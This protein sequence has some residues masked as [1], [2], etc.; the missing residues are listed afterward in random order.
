MDFQLCEFPMQVP[1]RMRAGSIKP[2]RVGWRVS[3]SEGNSAAVSSMQTNFQILSYA[4]LLTH[5]QIRA[6]NPPKI[7]V[8]F[9]LYFPIAVSFGCARDFASPC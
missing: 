3:L 1:N 9:Q 5:R 8:L 4:N 2:N 7:R 6:P